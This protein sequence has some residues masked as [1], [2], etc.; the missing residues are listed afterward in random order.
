MFLIDNY[1]KYNNGTLIHKEIIN[2]L[3]NPPDIKSKYYLNI[4]KLKDYKNIKDIKK[5]IMLLTIIFLIMMIII[6]FQ[7]FYY[8]DLKEEIRFNWLICY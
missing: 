6:I 8:T 2:K 3:L 7:I 1:R 5:F 4:D